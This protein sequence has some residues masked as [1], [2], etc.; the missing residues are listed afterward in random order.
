MISA[1]Q[2]GVMGR[3][4]PQIG[5]TVT[6]ARRIATLGDVDD[7][8]SARQIVEIVAGA[9]R[10]TST[11]PGAAGPIGLL[12]LSISKSAQAICDD[13]S[14]RRRNRAVDRHH[15]DRERTI[16]PLAGLNITLPS[17]VPDMSQNDRAL[18][19]NRNGGRHCCQPPL[20]RAKDLPVFVT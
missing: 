4:L 13:R 18:A 16:Q 14:C 2:Y 3:Y 7:R 10:P 12:W 11:P 6:P 5:E 8:L 17:Y 15:R 9:A 20:R 19:P 1:K